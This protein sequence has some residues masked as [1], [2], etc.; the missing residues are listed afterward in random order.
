MRTIFVVLNKYGVRKKKI[1]LLKVAGDKECDSFFPY[2]V[3]VRLG[4]DQA[5]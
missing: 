1:E 4:G 2:G 3:R 5:K